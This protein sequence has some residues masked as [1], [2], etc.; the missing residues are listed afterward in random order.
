MNS[1]KGEGRA[2]EYIRLTVILVVGTLLRVLLLARKSLWLDEVVTLQVA[3]MDIQDIIARSA[4]QWEPHP[5]FYYLLMHYWIRL[6]ESEFILRLPSAILGI[7]AIPI[8]YRLLRQWGETWGAMASAWLLAIAPLHI[9]YSQEARMYALV[10]T[11]GLASALCY[12]SGIRSGKPLDWGLWVILTALGLYTDYSMLLVL[13]AQA[14]LGAPLWK[15]YGRRG[16]HI[17]PLLAWLLLTLSFLPQMQMLLHQVGQISRGAGGYFFS[18]QVLLSR[19]GVEV[20]PTQLFAVALLAGLIGLAALFVIPWLILPRWERIRRKTYWLWLAVGLYLVVLAASAVLRGL[21]LKRQGLVLFPYILSGIATALSLSPRRLPLLLGLTLLTLPLTVYMAGI[22]EQESWRDTALLLEQQ[23]TPQDVI[24]IN[25]S[26]MQLPLD[27]YYRGPVLRYGVGPASVPDQL[28]GLIA[29]HSRVWL[30]LSSEIYTDPQ[31][32]VQRWL[33]Q[34]CS[35]T[36][37]HTFKRIRV[38]VYFCHK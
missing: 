35:F 11:L 28:S 10:C 23:A 9:W 6:G 17:W 12:S 14:A 2:R 37:E 34:R 31:G 7:I 13:A 38:R 30:I 22:Q 33:D 19:W 15:V 36:N 3:R 21:V 32:E 27:Y 4:T 18:V 24:L 1:L 20:T 29:G 25:A 5:P 8:L 16:T 26:Y